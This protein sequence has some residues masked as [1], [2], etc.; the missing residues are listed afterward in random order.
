[1]LLDNALWLGSFPWLGAHGQPEKYWSI[2][3]DQLDLFQWLN[4]PENHGTLLITSDPHDV[5]FLAS[6]YTPVRA[7][8]GHGMHTPDFKTRQQ[9]VATYLEEGKVLDAWRGKTLLVTLDRSF[10]E[11][12]W[13]SATGAQPVYENPGYRVFRVSPAIK[14]PN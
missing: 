14:P 3:T 10:P 13:L 5:G 11:P 7:W 12:R 6:V 1:L 8:F 9:E 2:T 4:R